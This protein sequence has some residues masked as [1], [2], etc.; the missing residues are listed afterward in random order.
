MIQALDDFDVQG[1]ADALSTVLAEARKKDAMTLWHLIARTG[2][3]ERA[4][5]VDHMAALVPMPQGVSRA[6]LVQGNAEMLGRWWDAV[7]VQ[8]VAPAISSPSEPAPTHEVR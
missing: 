7:R 2:G 3:T 6:G 4:D 5:I 8:P 1:R